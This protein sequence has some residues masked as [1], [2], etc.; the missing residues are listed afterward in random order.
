MFSDKPL[1]GLSDTLLPTHL[2]LATMVM[3]LRQSLVFVNMGWD[4]WLSSQSR[5]IARIS[6][7]P[8]CTAGQSSTALRLLLS[9]PAGT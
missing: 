8:D 7:K 2:A 3:R 5:V 9:G 4:Y 1:K 6:I